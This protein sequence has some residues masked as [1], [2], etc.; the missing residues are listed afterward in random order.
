[1]KKKRKVNLRFYI[2]FPY[3][4]F[5]TEKFISN[6]KEGANLYQRNLKHKYDEF[7]IEFT[8]FNM[9]EEMEE[10]NIDESGH[11]VFSNKKD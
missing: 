11:Y 5:N 8:A 10:G 7:G 2:N 6:V 9:N 4:Y 1:M 3:F